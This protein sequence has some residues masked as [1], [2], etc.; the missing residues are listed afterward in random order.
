M[1]NVRLEYCI[2]KTVDVNQLKLFGFK[3]R[4]NN[5][6]ILDKFLYRKIIKVK[7][8]ADLSEKII[9]WE[10]YDCTNQKQYYAFYNNV[11]GDNNRVAIKS[12][13][14]FNKVV[15]DLIE[16]KIIEEDE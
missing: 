13:E 11:N 7:L 3:P 4:T 8:I 14:E 5:T 2:P 6:Y 15:A 16:N 12:I 9:S 10:V 1:Q